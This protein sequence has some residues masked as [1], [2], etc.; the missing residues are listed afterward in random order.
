MGLDRSLALNNI[1]AQS[2]D[3]YGD[4][5]VSAVSEALEVD[6]D[7]ARRLIEEHMARIAELEGS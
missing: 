4:A 2:M 6:G 5:T 3:P 7:E 1:V